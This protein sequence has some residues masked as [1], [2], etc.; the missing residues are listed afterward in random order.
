M[1][2]KRK[3]K[4]QMR[5]LKIINAR[6]PD[7]EQDCIR[8]AELLIRDGKIEKIR[9]RGAITEETAETI[10]AKDQIVSAGFVDIHAHEDAPEGNFF[11]SECCL[12]MGVTTKI[13]G[14]CGDTF[15]DLPHFVE[16][17][18][19]SGSPTNYMIFLGQ[20]TLR[21]MV[22]A[23]DRYAPSTPEQLEKMKE[24]VKN[25]LPYA[26]VGLSC[27]FEYA[28]GITLEE[29]LD[30]LTAFD[31]KDYIV[32][33]HFRSDGPC[34]AA[35]TE[36][37]VELSKRS[38]YKVQMSHIG[39]C[40]AVG[41]MRDTLDVLDKA[42]AEGVD[43]MS[44]C[45][46]Y[47]AFCT[48]I[49]TA[50]F[51]EESFSKWDYS[52]LMITAGPYKNQRCTKELFEKLREE[53]PDMYVVAF[54]MNEEEIDMA[55]TQ[56]YVMVGSDCGFI[57]QAGHPRGAGTFPRIL[58]RYVRERKVMSLM[59]ALKKMTL[60]PAQRVNLTHKG[61][62]KEGYDADLVIFDENTIIDRATFEEPTLP[63]EGI[64]YVLLNGEVAVR[65]N[66]IVNGRLGTYIPYA[67]AAKR[68]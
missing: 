66:E 45:Y 4:K 6:I 22:G 60:L 50:V 35:S 16:R 46:P 65:N 42:R 3:E 48:G 52:D 7:Y 57:E 32:S 30:L 64:S 59:D 31:E 17:L 15:E 44:D 29:T 9:E 2:A 43:I 8:E 20:N 18:K 25:S 26:P 13:A 38:G 36:E 19:K 11:T 39:S 28:P 49:G 21:E 54:V 24:I 62:V 56:P 10:D 23:K 68:G 53:E 58:G 1:D 61:E 34:A 5:D 67:P 41:Y 37:V 27:G 47:H 63:P 33:V 14:N 55:Y 12:K 51:D 40:S